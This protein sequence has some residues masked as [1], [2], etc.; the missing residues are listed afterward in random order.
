[1]ST[2]TLSTVLRDMEALARS[3]PS[4][5]AASTHLLSYREKFTS[6]RAQIGTIADAELDLPANADAVNRIIELGKSLNE[7]LFPLPVTAPAPSP[8][9]FSTLSLKL[10]A[11]VM[12]II[13]N[14]SI[15]D[16]IVLGAAA[17]AVVYFGCRT[18]S[19]VYAV[20]SNYLFPPLPAQG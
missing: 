9:V 3:I 2:I 8:S 1:M 14:G 11:R 5:G 10:Q 19:A 15:V 13:K 4:E 17:A 7:K 16:K 18:V 20:A 12:H 6:L